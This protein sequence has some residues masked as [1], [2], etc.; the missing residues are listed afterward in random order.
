[1]NKEIYEF[2]KYYFNIFRNPQSTNGQVEEG[3]VE[4]CFALGF[5][6]DCGNSFKERYPNAFDSAEDLIRSLMK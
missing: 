2:A 5:E 3:F 1:M 4:K 6:M